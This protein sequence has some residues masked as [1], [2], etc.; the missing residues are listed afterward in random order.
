VA[1][2]LLG[3]ALLAYEVALARW[4][5]AWLTEQ[6]RSPWPAWRWLT[7]SGITWLGVI[8]IVDWV[9]PPAAGAIFVVVALVTVAWLVVVLVRGVR[10]LP[11]FVRQVRR[12]G[13][14]DAWRGIERPHR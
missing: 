8:L 9:S 7:R 11:E 4:T 3:C 2:A 14:P 1:L 12:I 5:A 10:G 6:G 13:D